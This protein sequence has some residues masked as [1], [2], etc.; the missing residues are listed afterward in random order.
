MKKLLFLISISIILFSCN[1]EIECDLGY[2]GDDCEI[3]ITPSLLKITKIKILSFPTGSYDI[4]SNPDLYIKIFYGESEIFVQSDYF[5][6][7][8]SGSTYTIN[9]SSP[10][11]II[12]PDGLYSI[13]LYDYDDIDSDDCIG[14]LEFYPY[15]GHGGFPDSKTISYAGYTFEVYYSYKW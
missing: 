11:N 13:V 15:T 6:N 14:G 2:T 10:I 5:L 4:G 9:F 8:N 3:Q 12:E 1:K 7:A